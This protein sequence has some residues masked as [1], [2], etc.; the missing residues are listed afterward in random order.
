MSTIHVFQVIRNL[1]RDSLYYL[2]D[3]FSL[4]V[5]HNTQ[6]SWYFTFFE[7]TLYQLRG[8]LRKKSHKPGDPELCAIQFLSGEP[9][10]NQETYH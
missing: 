1:V 10:A 4:L 6:V 2:Y 5:E 8:K 7:E 3:F 9:L